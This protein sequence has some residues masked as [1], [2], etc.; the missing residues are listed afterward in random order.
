MKVLLTSHGVHFMHY[1]L[2]QIEKHSAIRLCMVLPMDSHRVLSSYSEIVLKNSY[3]EIVLKN[4][5][6]EIVLKN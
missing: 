6:S 4:S 5:Y 3:S 1:F 2:S